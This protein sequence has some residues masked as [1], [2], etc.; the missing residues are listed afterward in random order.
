M[1][2]SPSRRKQGSRAAALRS[3]L[4]AM[5]GV[6]T[7]PF[8]SQSRAIVVMAQNDPGLKRLTRWFR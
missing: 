6:L 8:P 2:D 3:V 5:L 4:L 1:S 7:G